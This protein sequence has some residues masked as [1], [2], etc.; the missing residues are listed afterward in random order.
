M[1]GISQVFPFLIAPAIRPSAHRTP[2]LRGVIPQYSDS[3]TAVR[4]S[5]FVAPS[6][7]YPYDAVLYIMYRNKAIIISSL[8]IGRN[9]RGEIGVNLP[10]GNSPEFSTGK[11]G[12]GGRWH[13]SLALWLP[14][15]PSTTTRGTLD[16]LGQFC[17]L[18]LR[19]G[20]N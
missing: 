4:Y 6:M 1:A 13:F 12:E 7:L 17:G 15:S 10:V 3:S 19:F 20:T 11:E 2:I 14:P 5:M 18:F 8:R 9:A 16:A